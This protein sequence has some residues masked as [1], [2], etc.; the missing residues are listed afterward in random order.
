[1]ILYLYMYIT[2]VLQLDDLNEEEDEEEL[3]GQFDKILTSLEAY[4]KPLA[5]L[6]DID[7]R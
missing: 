4:V 7:V 2:C 6:L 3:Q 5:G 1:M